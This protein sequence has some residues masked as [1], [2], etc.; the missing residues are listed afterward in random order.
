MFETK[1]LFSNGWLTFIAI[2]DEASSP[3]PEGSDK[4]Q[5]QFPESVVVGFLIV[6]RHSKLFAE[7]STWLSVPLD[8]QRCPLGLKHHSVVW[9]ESDFLD[10]LH[11]SKFG[12]SSGASVTQKSSK[13]CPSYRSFVISF[14]FS[15]IWSL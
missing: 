2:T 3:F 1:K 15:V 10:H 6:T 8:L 7:G 11:V 13:S 12:T 14:D 4:M 9:P 5:V